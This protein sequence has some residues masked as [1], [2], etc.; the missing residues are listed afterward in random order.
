MSKTKWAVPITEWN[1]LVDT[2]IRLEKALNYAKTFINGYGNARLKE[3]LG[4]DGMN[5]VLK[6][7]DKMANTVNRYPVCPIC[8]A[9][10]GKIKEFHPSNTSIKNFICIVC[11]SQF[12]LEEYEA[13]TS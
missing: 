11:D 9:S 4:R 6:E 8:C 12:N 7:I 5:A 10:I 3:N 1:K 13:L 2:K